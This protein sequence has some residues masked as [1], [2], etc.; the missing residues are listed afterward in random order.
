MSAT[1][2]PPRCKCKKN[3]ANNVQCELYFF[4]NVHFFLISATFALKIFHFYSA[5]LF[6]WYTG[7]HNK[8]DIVQ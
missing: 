8:W 2:Y 6:Y 5:F 7:M 4:K 1:D 3:L